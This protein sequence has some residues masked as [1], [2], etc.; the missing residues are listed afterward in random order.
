MA[1][2]GLAEPAEGVVDQI[3]LSSNTPGSSNTLDF[4]APGSRGNEAGGMRSMPLK[5]LSPGSVRRLRRSPA[6][7]LAW[8]GGPLWYPLQG[9]GAEG[10]H[11][12]KCRLEVRDPAALVGPPWRPGVTVS[13]LQLLSQD[14][15]S[16]GAPAA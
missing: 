14:P 10:P 9:S 4:L 3:T 1:G 7:R 6:G 5:G 13:L 12:S 16:P 8:A 15:A 11:G 2:V